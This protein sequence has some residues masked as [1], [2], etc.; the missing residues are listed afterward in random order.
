MPGSP[1]PPRHGAAAASEPVLGNWW[2]EP[3]ILSTV[4]EERVIRPLTYCEQKKLA[5]DLRLLPFCIF[6]FPQ[7]LR[8]MGSGSG[9]TSHPFVRPLRSPS[10][11]PDPRVPKAGARR[12]SQGWPSLKSLNKL[13]D[14]RPLLDCLEHDGRLGR[15]G[16]NRNPRAV[17]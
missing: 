16:I 8:R 7:A 9:K 2:H 11:R 13:R 17:A 10:F 14:S 5:R 1:Q 6:R 4:C 12:V 15:V 3:R